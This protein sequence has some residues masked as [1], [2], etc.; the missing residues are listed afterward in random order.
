VTEHQEP[1]AGP[2]DASVTTTRTQMVRHGLLVRNR[3]GDPVPHHRPAAAER[4]SVH[5]HPTYKE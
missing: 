1:H 4:Q 3:S 2:S 5:A